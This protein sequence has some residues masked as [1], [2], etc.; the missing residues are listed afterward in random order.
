MQEF[1][2]STERLLD[3]R[4][5]LVGDS[6]T[7]E[8]AAAAKLAEFDNES[9]TIADP[10]TKRSMCALRKRT[11][12]DI[13]ERIATTRATIKQLDAVLTKGND[14]QHAA[15]CVLIADSLH[16]HGEDIDQTLQQAKT[17]AT[18]YAATTN[19]LLARINR[20]LAD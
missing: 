10:A 18:Q 8:T 17:A 5:Q 2:K 7:Y 14:L 6:N 11:Q 9:N 12:E 20:A 3:L 15:K 4:E 13:N 19:T 1:G 16:Q